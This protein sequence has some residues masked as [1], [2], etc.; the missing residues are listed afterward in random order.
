M[1]ANTIL[2]VLAELYPEA[3]CA[4]HHRSTYELLVATI[5]SAQCTD[6]RVNII[7]ERL[8]AEAADPQAMVELGVDR[9][10]E[11]IRGCG[12][13]NNKANNLVS[14]SRRLLENHAGQVPASREE[15]EALAGVGR[16]TANV[17]L[18][19][20]FGQPAI[21]VDT[22]VFRVAN[23]IGLST[24]ANPRQTEEQ[25]MAAIP[26]RRWIQ[27]HHLLIFHGRNLCSARQPQCA[28]CPL[29]AVCS[30]Y[31]GGAELA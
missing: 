11:L 18:S 2:D 27:A 24:G 12:L 1:D 9:V 4:L 22:H 10:R 16:K 29:A 13:Y 25:L 3:A 31:R 5:L 21:A 17:V 23:R 26:R 14:A 19:T 6:A 15:L 8:F 20:G 28:N 7:T 30:Y